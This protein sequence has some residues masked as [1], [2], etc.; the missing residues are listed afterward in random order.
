MNPNITK[1]INHEKLVEKFTTL[2]NRLDQLQ[3]ALI[4]YDSVIKHDDSE[5]VLH[6]M[7]L[8]HELGAYE[9]SPRENYGRQGMYKSIVE[10]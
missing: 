3:E 8:M 4:N 5:G 2:E 9:S 1:N 6:G 10:N 7:K